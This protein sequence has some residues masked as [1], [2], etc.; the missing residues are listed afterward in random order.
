MGPSKL[1]SVHTVVFDRDNEKNWCTIDAAQAQVEGPV[2]SWN[3][4]TWA[5]CG[6]A[7]DP[8]LQEKIRL[9]KGEARGS[10][11]PVGWTTFFTERVLSTIDL[12]SVTDRKIRRLMGDQNKLTERLGGLAF[13]RA[14]ADM[15]VKE[16]EGIPDSI[17][18]PMQ[19]TVQIYSVKGLPVT[20]NITRA[21][22]ALGGEPVMTSANQSGH[23]EAISLD[24]AKEFSE[25]SRLAVPIFDSRPSAKVLRKPRGSYPVIELRADRFKIIRP[26]WLNQALMGQ[27]LHGYNVEFASDRELARSG[28]AP[29]HPHHVLC[30]ED[31]SDPQRKLRGAD[32]RQVLLDRLVQDD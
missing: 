27:L 8:D 6:N 9:I 30:P 4:A 11:Q 14:I 20:E 24:Q 18:P 13:I 1:V 22:Q 28:Q 26:G 7:N 15:D 29:N 16:R 5:L 32:L 3:Y 21:V 2:L 17:I 31:L 12:R 10:R 19:A 23:A 25:Q